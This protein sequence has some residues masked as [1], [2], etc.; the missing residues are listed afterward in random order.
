MGAHVD[1]FTDSGLRAHTAY[2]YQ[3]AA[4]NSRGESPPG[5][6]VTAST[7]S[8]F[9]EKGLVAFWDFDDE[10]SGTVVDVTGNGHNGKVAGEVVA[11]PGILI[12]AYTF[13]GTGVAPAHLAVPNSPAFQFTA[14]QSFTLS[15]WIKPIHIHD[16]EQAV[17]AKSADQGSPYGIWIDT[18]NRWVFRGPNGDLVGPPAQQDVWTHLAVVQDATA[19]TRSIYVNGKLAASAPGTQPA[20]GPGDLWMGQQNVASRPE[21]FPGL[22]DEVRIYNRAL[23]ANEIPPLLTAPVWQ[24]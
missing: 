8:F 6:A 1:S 15:A 12:G 16:T 2:Y 7:F 9:N 20:D 24:R 13:H 21:S 23:D 10:N 11:S 22:I 17:I 19:K 5:P 14:E 18:G 4:F 3:V